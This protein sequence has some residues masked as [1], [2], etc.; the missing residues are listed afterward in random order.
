MNISADAS[1]LD[2]A[3]VI[4]ASTTISGEVVLSKLLSVLMNIVIE[5]AGAQ[6]AF[7]LLERKGELFI[8]AQVET[9]SEATDVHHMPFFKSGKLAES[10]VSFV[11]RTKESI[12]MDDAVS[13]T[14][15]HADEYIRQ[16]KPIS[17]LCLPIIHLGKFIGLLYLENNLVR[18]AFTENRIRILQLLSGQIAVS[19]NN[20]LLYDELEQ[21][22]EERTVELASEKK[23][24]DD[25]LYNIL[26]YETAQELKQFGKTEAR[27][28]ESASVLFTDFVGFTSISE[29]LSPTELVTEIGECFQAFDHIAEKYGIEKIKTI[30][31]S[32]MAAGGIPVPNTTHAEN[33]VAAAMEILAFMRQRNK[34][35]KLAKFELRLGINSGSLVAG[36]VGYKKIQYDIWGDTV[37]TASRMEQ[38]SQP[39]RINISES[40]YELIKHKYPCE[41]RGEIEAKGKGKVKMY[42]VKAE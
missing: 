40:T 28:F 34:N 5:N 41:Y 36:V 25:L 35:T 39:G 7:I 21:K 8:E 18:G 24:S 15:F 9:D 23:K 27:Q 14:R 37:N 31:D 11:S 4:K 1:D 20:A 16:Q 2:L 6:R 19:I 29:K 13:D 22:V 38:H 3:S 42:F 10:V 32:Y 17:V 30:G 26:P 33:T 12:V